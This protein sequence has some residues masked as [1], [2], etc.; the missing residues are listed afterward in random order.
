VN[1]GAMLTVIHDGV[2][3]DEKVVHSLALLPGII[4]SFTPVQVEVITTETLLPPL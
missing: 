4:I 2:K 3:V 1:A